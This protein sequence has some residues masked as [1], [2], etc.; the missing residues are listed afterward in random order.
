MGACQDEITPQNPNLVNVGRKEI[1]EYLR[2]QYEE[3][4]TSDK[5]N[6]P[7]KKNKKG[8][9]NKDSSLVFD[10]EKNRDLL[11]CTADPQTCLLHSTTIE[12]V[13]WLFF[14]DKNQLDDLVK[15]LNKRGL[16]ENEL[17]RIIENDYDQLAKIISQTPVQQLNPD[18]EIDENLKT[19]AA[20]KKVKNRYEDANLGFPNDADPE[21]VLHS[22]TVD[23]ILEMEEKIFAGTLGSLTVKDRSAWR[24]C[25]LNGDYDN[26]DTSFLKQENGKLNLD[27]VKS[28]NNSRASTPDSITEEKKTEYSDPGKYLGATLDIESEDSDL[29][30]DRLLLTQNEMNKKTISTLA[31]A[32]VQLGYAVEPKYLKKPLGK[33]EGS[34][35][36][37][38]KKDRGDVLDN[39]AK[40]LRASTSYS[41]IFLHYSTLD[42]CIMWS[43]STLLARCRICR[44]QK[45]SENMLLCDSC[46]N[47]HHLYCLK[48]KLT[49]SFFL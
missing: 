44:R 32:L 20:A 27:K 36:D 6:S 37:D 21:V 9:N 1:L 39:W 26:L 38:K 15:S 35:K 13:R 28:E 19:K 29:E 5:E 10:K 18:V 4:N 22:I 3:M 43:K 46:N 24:E 42:S 12:R 25:L 47:G 31:L 34:K 41:Q 45:D 8:I 7:N 2:K 30:C 17:Q 14:S 16:R 23:N 33:M 49:V 48:P 11:M 40:S